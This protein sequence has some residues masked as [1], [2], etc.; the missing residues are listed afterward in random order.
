MHEVKSEAPVISDAIFP[1]TTA[2]LSKSDIQ[3]LKPYVLANF[4]I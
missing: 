3:V 2:A 4:E 1:I